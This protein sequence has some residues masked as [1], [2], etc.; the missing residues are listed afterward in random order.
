[1]SSQPAA[2]A[3]TTGISKSAAKKRAKK[4]AKALAASREGSAAAGAAASDDFAS[5]PSSALDAKLAF[6]A[7]AGPYP[8]AA[9]FNYYDDAADAHLHPATAGLVSSG[10]RQDQF[11]F[12][13]Y[14]FGDRNLVPQANGSPF[15]GLSQ[16]INI[17]HEDLLETANELWKRM[18]ETAYGEDDPYW[19][20]LP[21][22]VRQ[23]IREAIPF[24]GLSNTSNDPQATQKDLY[25]MAQRIV[26]AASQGMGLQGVGSNLLSQVNGR[27]SHLQPSIAEDL[28]FHRHP[29]AAA[30]QEDD[31]E[32]EEEFEEEH[33]FHVQPNGDTAPKKKNKKRRKKNNSSA[34]HSDPPPAA[35]PPLAALEFAHETGTPATGLYSQNGLWSDDSDEE[36]QRMSW[37]QRL[38]NSTAGDRRSVKSSKSNGG[39]SHRGSRSKMDSIISPLSVESPWPWS[40]KSVAE[41]RE[42]PPANEQQEVLAG[43]NP[44]RGGSGNRHSGRMSPSTSIS[45]C[46]QPHPGKHQHTA[47]MH[48]ISSQHS[49]VSA[50]SVASNDLS[51]KQRISMG[52]LRR[53]STSKGGFNDFPD[54]VPAVPQIPAALESTLSIRSQKTNSRGSLPGTAGDGNSSRRIATLCSRFYACIRP[55]QTSGFPCSPFN[56]V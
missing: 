46:P 39:H 24:N 9:S 18:G 19:S 8:D 33:D 36:E 51:L 52:R 7:A 22:H 23:F 20:S 32:D 1:M 34:N 45:S 37:R 5:A 30:G 43:D 3:A 10:P 15:G 26:H 25:A 6:S 31:F 42:S 41:R 11:S 13:S 44:V 17:T 21:P 12:A 16:S 28:G 14:A 54:V 53:K 55:V 27:A 2:N 47:S 48:S 4:A 38:S 40:R 49:T 29:D 56:A 50:A 35:L